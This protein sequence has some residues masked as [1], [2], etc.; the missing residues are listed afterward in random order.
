MSSSAGPT[1][2]TRDTLLVRFRRRPAAQQFA[3]AASA[4]IALLLIL[5]LLFGRPGDAPP[6][7]PG[8]TPVGVLVKIADS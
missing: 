6:P 7:A 1:H 2:E 5:Y 4:V 8:P 3:I